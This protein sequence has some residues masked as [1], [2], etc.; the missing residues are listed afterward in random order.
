LESLG[1]KTAPASTSNEKW[2]SRYW[3]LEPQAVEEVV[4]KRLW[5]T[6]RQE[7]DDD[8][9]NAGLYRSVTLHMPHFTVDVSAARTLPLPEGAQ[10]KVFEQKNGER[11]LRLAWNDPP[12]EVEVYL[13]W[14]E[15]PDTQAG[16]ALLMCRLWL[17]LTDR[18][19]VRSALYTEG[20]TL[21]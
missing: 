9:P 3:V 18:D 10:W 14:H 15:V 16:E 7:V 17:E 4:R 5:K 19:D 2:V 21:L 8:E 12:P 1:E 11:R 13:L 6:F 20:V